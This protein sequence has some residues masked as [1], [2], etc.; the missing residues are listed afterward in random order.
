MLQGIPIVLSGRFS[1]LEDDTQDVR[2]RT[3]VT[4]DGDDKP[5]REYHG[6]GIFECP[7]C[8]SYRKS[9]GHARPQEVIAIH[10]ARLAA[11]RSATIGTVK[12]SFDPVGARTI[13]SGSFPRV[14]PPDC[15]EPG[16]IRFADSGDGKL[17]N[18]HKALEW[19]RGQ[20][21]VMA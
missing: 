19:W 15:V 21:P 11:K 13:R 10:K 18:H 12:D 17:C 20:Q 2:P 6:N 14:R 9:S 8:Y 16:C 7:N 4:C 5:L 3:C 1:P